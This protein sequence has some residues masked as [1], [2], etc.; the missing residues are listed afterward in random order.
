MNVPGYVPGFLQPI[1]NRVLMTSTGIRAQVGVK[2]FGDNLDALQQKAFE[3]ERVIQQIQGATGVAPSRVQG[4]P[5]LEITVRRDELGRYGLR[6]DDLFRYV[7]AG[8]GGVTVGTH[9]QGAR[10]LAAPGTAGAGRPR[11]HR[12]AW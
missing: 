4:K 6:V 10:T 1:E 5:Y 2:I 8:L 11:R 12:K 3:V 7:E 9:A